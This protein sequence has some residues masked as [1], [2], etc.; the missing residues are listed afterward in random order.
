MRTSSEDFDHASSTASRFPR[1]AC[2]SAQQ[3]SEK[4]LKAVLVRVAGDVP[5]SHLSTHLVAEAHHLGL[6]LPGEV[7]EA[8]QGLDKY[9][10][11]TRYPDA[12]GG[13]APADVYHADD[14]A[15][16][17]AQ[18]ERVLVYARQFFADEG[19]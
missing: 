4:A 12:V 19:P 16:A 2:F 14:A 9:Y 17:L 6:K 15:L 8:A 3:A 1:L 5:R 13:L 18:A 7:I 10:G 11:A